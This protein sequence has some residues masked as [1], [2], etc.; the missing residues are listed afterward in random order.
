M[1]SVESDPRLYRDPVPLQLGN[2]TF[3]IRPM[4]DGQFSEIDNWI[5]QTYL[6]RIEEASGGNDKYMAMLLPSIATVNMF[7][8]A[9]GQR[10]FS[11][12]EGLAQTLWICCTEETRPPEPSTFIELMLNKSFRTKAGKFWVDLN[13]G[14]KTESNS[15]G[16]SSAEKTGSDT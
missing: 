14:P 16:E 2:Q 6:R 5:R 3:Q 11:S 7:D 15:S 8:G 10:L 12:I 9:V 13:S 1:A 4:S